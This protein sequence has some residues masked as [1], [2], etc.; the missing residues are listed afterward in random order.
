MICTD[1]RLPLLLRIILQYAKFLVR[2]VSSIAAC[3][4]SGGHVS[5]KPP[6]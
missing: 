4:I 1:K 3:A 6:I 5:P 2:T